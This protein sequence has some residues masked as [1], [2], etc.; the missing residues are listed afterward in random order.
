MQQTPIHVSENTDWSK[1]KAENLNLSLTVILK[2]ILSN[3]SL[4]ITTT[5]FY[6]NSYT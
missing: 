1:G 2:H 5:N 3:P 6:M 4:H